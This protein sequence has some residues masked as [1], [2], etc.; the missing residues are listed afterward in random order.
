MA[1]SSK[2]VDRILILVSIIGVL[3]MATMF[4]LVLRGPAATASGPKRTVIAV[5][6]NDFAITGDLNALEGQVILQVTNYGGTT[7]NLTMEN[8]PATPD[9]IP[10][11]SATLNLGEL[12]A[13]SYRLICTKPGHESAGMSVIL[14]VGTGTTLED[15][16]SHARGTDYAAMD[17]AMTESILA[18]PAATE[19]KGRKATPPQ[20]LEAPGMMDERSLRSTVSNPSTRLTDRSESAVSAENQEVAPAS[21]LVGPASSSSNAPSMGS[22]PNAIWRENPFTSPQLADPSTPK[23]TSIDCPWG[24]VIVVVE[25]TLVDTV[26][27]A[28][29]VEGSEAP[30][31]AT[32]TRSHTTRYDQ[33]EC[34]IYL[35]PG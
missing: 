32:T 33:V 12:T 20:E 16:S 23:N 31:Q 8:G 6:L 29:E 7:H 17:A 25:S 4:V 9:L 15:A 21:V 11:D 30:A 35:A 13:G 28:V 34:A 2:A 26:G 27:S 14:T 3:V 22:T 18:F 24:S 1:D 10:G 5:V 19:G